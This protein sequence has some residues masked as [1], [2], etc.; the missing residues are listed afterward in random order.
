MSNQSLMYKIERLR[1]QMTDVALKKGITSEESL[2][3]SQEL[4]QL[5]NI[6]ESKKQK[7]AADENDRNENK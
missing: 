1:K 5:L 4:D 7:K 6:Y 2:G 3:I